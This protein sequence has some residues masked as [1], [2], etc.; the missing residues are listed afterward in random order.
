MESQIVHTQNRQD[1]IA[2]LAPESET[3]SDQVHVILMLEER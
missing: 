3:F 2:G 1:Q